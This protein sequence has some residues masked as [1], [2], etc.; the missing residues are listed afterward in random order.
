MGAHLRTQ[1]SH[2]RFR[3]G[4]GIID[5]LLSLSWKEEKSS[6]MNGTATANGQ[7][8]LCADAC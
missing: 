6:V 3:D 4:S 2:H 7:G 8:T 5:E 1:L